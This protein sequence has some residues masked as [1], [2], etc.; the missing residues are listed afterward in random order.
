MRTPGLMPVLAAGV[1]MAGA[2]RAAD[3][4]IKVYVDPAT[5]WPSMHD[6]QGVGSAMELASD[7]AKSC[8]L[9][10]T[11]D[12]AAQWKVTVYRQGGGGKAVI[13][14]NGDLVHEFRPG[15][16]TTLRKTAERICA[17]IGPAR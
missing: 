15:F 14:R 11:S 1:V 17:W 5:K 8:G 10:V 6:T 16:S 3:E 7:L 12:P 4:A 2:A 13:W 9:T